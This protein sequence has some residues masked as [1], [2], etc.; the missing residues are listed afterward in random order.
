MAFDRLTPGEK[1]VV[2]PCMRLA[3]EGICDEVFDAFVRLTRSEL[4]PVYSRW[5]YLDDNDSSV[6]VAVDD[7]LRIGLL[8]A[9]DRLRQ[10]Q[11]VADLQDWFH[12]PP[13]EINRVVQRLR[14]LRGESYDVMVNDYILRY[15]TVNEHS[16]DR[17]R[18][19]ALHARLVDYVGI[20]AL[21]V[22]DCLLSVCHAERHGGMLPFLMIPQRRAPDGGSR[23]TE[24]LLVPE[25]DLLFVEVSGHIVAYDLVES[26]KLWQEAL[27]SD[28]RSWSMHGNHVL[29]SAEQESTAWNL[30]GRKLWSLPVE[31][32]GGG[33]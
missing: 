24:A 2:R 6:R 4:A 25:T 32:L 20:R 30:I 23:P 1:E 14:K 5:P 7:S 31:L 13:V 22:S 33:Q 18:S 29:M 26:R 19:L 17:C 21:E 8:A 15:E 10:V 3:L 27:D 28:F 16:L 11:D 12:L 9:Y